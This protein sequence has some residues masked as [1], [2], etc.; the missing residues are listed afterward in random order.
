[1]GIAMLWIVFYHSVTIPI[2]GLV[3][4]HRIGYGGVDIFLLLSGIGI[5]LSF[6][7]DLNFKSF[8]KRRL[9][10]IYPAY[11]PAFFLFAMISYW[12]GDVDFLS[13]IL[14]ATGIGYWAGIYI[15]WYIPGL[16]VLYLIAPFI[17]KYAANKLTLVIVVLIV[18]SIALTLWMVDTS[19]A[20]LLIFTSRIP[21]F[22]IGILV[23][24]AIKNGVVLGTKTVYS[25]LFLL[26]VGFGTMYFLVNRYTVDGLADMGLCWYPLSFLA[27]PISMTLALFFDRFKKH[28]FSILSCVGTYS[29]AIFIFHQRILNVL[30]MFLPEL[31]W[32]RYAVVSILGLPI[33]FILAY[34]FQ[35]LVNKAVDY[36]FG[37]ADKR[38]ESKR[39]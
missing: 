36:F 20:Y 6:I 28:K 25:V 13:V 37:K 10:R 16:L 18:A 4:F 32:D 19:L 15:D 23:G 3:F 14:I 5:Y 21:I 38:I 31:P 12:V 22:L 27:F 2:P 9:M 34:Y 17:I 30:D 26:L 39:A 29:L 7:K 33:T 24:Q 8:Y 11:V 1:M 35:N